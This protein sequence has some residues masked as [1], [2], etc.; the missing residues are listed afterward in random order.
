MAHMLKSF[1]LGN[2]MIEKEKACMDYSC[3]FC[4]AQAVACNMV[5]GLCLQVVAR[6][7]GLCGAFVQ[8]EKYTGYITEC[9]TCKY[10][11]A[12]GQC[13]KE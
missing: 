8:N 11:G 4:D 3:R 10:F 6:H 7:V 5:A 2:G 1:D 13:N 9:S 12:D